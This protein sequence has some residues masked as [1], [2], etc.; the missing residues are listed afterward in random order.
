MQSEIFN[1]GNCVTM[2]RLVR[3]VKG[4]DEGVGRPPLSTGKL[5]IIIVPD[6]SVQF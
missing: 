3:G 5:C 4:G 6:T 1:D 2:W